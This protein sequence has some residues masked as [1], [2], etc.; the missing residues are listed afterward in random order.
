MKELFIGFA[1]HNKEANK[2]VY[3]ILDGLSN[4]ERE[5]DQGSY[6]KSLSGI[7][8]H[9]L[10]GTVFLLGMLKEALK[11]SPALEALSALGSVTVPKEG[12]DAGQW[13]ALGTAFEK[14]DDAYIDLVSSLRE[15][16]FKAPVKLSWYK[17]NPPAVP[18]AFMLQQLV[19]HGVHHR[20]QISQILDSLKIDNDYSGISP[21]FIP[22][23]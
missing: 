10:G 21:A 12:L 2:A 22:K 9:V 5:K 8:V 1:K 6:Y 18:V 23:L 4:D 16:D 15:E 11:G 14:A 17:D 13:K 7:F 20:G 3:A 19:S